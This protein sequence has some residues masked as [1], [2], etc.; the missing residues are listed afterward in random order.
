MSLLDLYIGRTIVH[1]ALVVMAVLVGL[2]SL[3][4]FIDQIADIGSGDYGVLRAFAFVGLS[5]PR[6]VYEV[7]PMATLL[8]AILG[9]SSMARDSELIVIRA[10]GVSVARI[11]L[12]ALKFGAFF[13][14]V[15][16]LIGELVSPYSETLAQQ[17]KAKALHR[18]IDQATSFGLWFRDGDTYVNVNEVMP[19]LSLRGI[20]IF[21]FA[22]RCRRPSERQA[23]P[24]RHEGKRSPKAPESGASPA[25]VDCQTRGHDRLHSLVDAAVANFVGGAWEM[26]DGKTTTIDAEGFVQMTEFVRQAW[27]TSVTQEMMKMFAVQPAQLSMT[28]LRRYIDHL[29]RNHQDTRA[30]E[31]AYWGKWMLP[32]STAV[33]VVL[34]IPFVLGS[35]RA[36]TM[37]RNLFLGSL[38]GLSFFFFSQVF[39][40][41]VLVYGVPP[42]LGATLPSVIFLGIA[43][44]MYRRVL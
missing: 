42:L 17:I 39:G 40:Y 33:M 22:D 30:T 23:D 21:Q 14:L 11:T 38:M 25:R 37:G 13:V 6:I 44:M 34:A 19:N 36:G 1:Q 24:I 5:V 12:S 7:F 20:K 31:L 32:I 18:N 16:I 15:A 26:R 29:E 43:M 35:I 4:I 41:A 8:G 27:Q 9:L 10:S 28:Q 3:V 2:F